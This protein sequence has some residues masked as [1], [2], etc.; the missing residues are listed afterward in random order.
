MYDKFMIISRIIKHY[1]AVKV[2]ADAEHQDSKSHISRLLLNAQYALAERSENGHLLDNVNTRVCEYCIRHYPYAKLTID[3][4]NPRYFK[5]ANSKDN[6]KIVCERC[7][8]AKGAIDP[9]RMPV[10]F[11]RLLQSFKQGVW[12][13]RLEFLQEMKTSPLEV[14][15]KDLIDKLIKMESRASLALKE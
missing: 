8:K 5:G 3:H 12:P 7:N 10:T 9:Q 11:S 13:L 14:V 15:E 2:L 6:L 1:P 4:Y